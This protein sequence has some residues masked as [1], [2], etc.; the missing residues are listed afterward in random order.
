MAIVGIPSF[1][2][3]VDCRR[4][5]CAILFFHGVCVCVFNPRTE[6]T[7]SNP[8]HQLRLTSDLSHGQKDI[9]RHIGPSRF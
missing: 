5:Q 9:R 2:F 6:P 7:Y 3:T 4:G 8:Y 1:R